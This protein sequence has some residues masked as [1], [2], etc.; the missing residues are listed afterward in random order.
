[1]E[2]EEEEQRKREEGREEIRIIEDRGRD[3]GYGGDRRRDDYYDRDRDDR[4]GRRGKVAV[5][6]E[7]PKRRWERL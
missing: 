5:E 2:I 7:R 3:R 6:I 4:G 1:M